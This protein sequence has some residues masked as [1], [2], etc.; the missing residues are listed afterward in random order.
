[1]PVLA[2]GSRGIYVELLQSTLKKIGFYFGNVDGI[3]GQQTLDSVYYFQDQFGIT[4]DGVVGRSTWLKLMPY[5]NGTVGNIVPT[6]MSYPY[7]I[8]MLNLDALRIKYPIVKVE[9]YFESVMGKK[10]PVIK[11]RRG[12][13]RGIL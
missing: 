13:R 10:V 8:M 12:R 5:I 2:F 6:D 7:E 11:L 9:Y 4:V 3:F 1:M